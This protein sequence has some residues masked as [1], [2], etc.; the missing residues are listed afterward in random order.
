MINTALHEL[1]TYEMNRIRYGHGG[2]DVAIAYLEFMHGLTEKQRAQQLLYDAIADDNFELAKEVLD[3]NI[4]NIKEAFDFTDQE[5][6]DESTITHMAID[7]VNVGMPDKYMFLRYAGYTLDEMLAIRFNTFGD[8]MRQ[9]ELTKTLEDVEASI[10]QANPRSLLWTAAK[11]LT[12]DQRNAVQHIEEVK[13]IVNKA[14]Y[15]KK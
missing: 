12:D 9:L 13:D 4:V 11:K 3:L 10:V 2:H 8:N 15:F 1:I 6:Q 7:D 14:K 5:A